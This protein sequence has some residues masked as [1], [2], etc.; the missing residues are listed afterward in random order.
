MTISF[1]RGRA[2]GMVFRAGHVDTILTVRQR[3]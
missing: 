2:I 1:G 3:R